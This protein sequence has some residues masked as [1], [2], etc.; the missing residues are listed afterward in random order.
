MVC[1]T[2]RWTYARP[3]IA[4]WAAL[5][6]SKLLQVLFSI[7]FPASGSSPFRRRNTSSF[8]MPCSPNS[9]PIASWASCRPLVRSTMLC[10]EP[11]KD[12]EAGKC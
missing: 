10:F 6:A 2:P 9:T 8:T 11:A 7:L 4:R 12:I 3:H 5:A 1:S